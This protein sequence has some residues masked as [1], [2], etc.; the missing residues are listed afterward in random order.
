MA[1]E[2]SAP[3]CIK[4]GIEMVV[5][6]TEL[7]FSS[8][9][10]IMHVLDWI[11]FIVGVLMIFSIP[12]LGWIMGAIICIWAFLSY[13][14]FHGERPALPENFCNTS[15]PGA[16]LWRAAKGKENDYCCNRCGSM[17]YQGR[18]RRGICFVVGL[19]LLT[20]YVSIRWFGVPHF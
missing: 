8:E 16:I 5:H 6:V 7:E 19:L 11:V 9:P 17:V 1:R 12:Y 18:L 3:I 20:A 4:C 13:L 2:T 15:G 10:L 14:S